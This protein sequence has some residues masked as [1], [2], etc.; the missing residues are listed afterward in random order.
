[1]EGEWLAHSDYV[2]AKDNF[3]LLISL[4][5]VPVR[6]CERVGVGRFVRSIICLLFVRSTFILQLPGNLD[7]P[8]RLFL[9]WHV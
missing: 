5:F 2:N 8:F 4:L 3:G 7:Y 9:E 1:M 6:A